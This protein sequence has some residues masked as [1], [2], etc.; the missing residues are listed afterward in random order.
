MSPDVSLDLT[1]CQEYKLIQILTGDIQ[2]I[3]SDSIPGIF[4]LN[5]KN[6]IF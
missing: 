5:L 2:I 1:A 6:D 3:S 4:K